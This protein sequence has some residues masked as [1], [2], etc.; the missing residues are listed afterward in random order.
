VYGELFIPDAKVCIQTRAKCSSS[1]MYPL[2][3]ELLYE[4]VVRCFPSHACGADFTT[5]FTM[6]PT[7]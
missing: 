5:Q 3:S 1:G 2:M 4:F 6:Q 7:C